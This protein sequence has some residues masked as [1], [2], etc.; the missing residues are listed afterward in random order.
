MNEQEQL[1]S[2]KFGDDYTDRMQGNA[3]L[4]SNIDFFS[5]ALIKTTG[6][7]TILEL[8][9]NRGMNL[10]ALEY[11]DQSTIKTGVDINAKALLE[12]TMMFE[13]L[14]LDY[15]FVHCMPIAK[16]ESEEQY[17]LVFTKG[18]LIHINPDQLAE[19]YEKMYNLSRKYI[20]IAEYYNP[21]PV[22]VPYHG[23]N[24]KLFKRDFAGEMLDKY[25]LKL[26]DYGFVYHRGEHPQDDINWFLMERK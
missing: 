26:I 11:L 15:P 8:G 17:D 14:G 21:T 16:Y 25:P 4:E 20:L 19:V 5:N 12:L 23:M 3:L 1:W 22:E 6:I 24:G 2:A 9:C 18:V 7:S 10:A 13:R